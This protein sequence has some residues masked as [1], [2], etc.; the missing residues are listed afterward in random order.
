MAV[1]FCTLFWCVFTGNSWVSANGFYVRYFFPVVLGIVVVL[2]VPIAAALLRIP[3]PRRSRLSRA[4][5]P[6]I[7]TV[8]CIGAML[9]PFTPPS[10]SVQLL[11]TRTTADY[12]KANDVAFL[13]GYFWTVW[14]IELQALENG[15]TA[16]YV[17]A[18]K[19]GGDRENYQAALDRELAEG[20]GPPK[21]VCVDDEMTSCIAYLEYWTRPGWREVAGECPVPISNPANGSPPVEA[22]RLLE[23]SPS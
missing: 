17:T 2:T 6:V 9:G 13:S 12:I 7:A 14:P 10:Q 22:C 5:A 16:T 19:S 18:G 15:R 20:D 8:L 21:A 1:L 4:I 11:A 23:F 3:S